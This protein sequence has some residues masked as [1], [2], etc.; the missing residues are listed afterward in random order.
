VKLTTYL[1]LVPRSRMMELYYA[2]R[3][4]SVMLNYAQGQLNRLFL[5]IYRLNTI[6]Q[7]YAH[8]TCISAY[9]FKLKVA[10][11][12]LQ[13]V[14]GLLDIRFIS[15]VSTKCVRTWADRM[16]ETQDS[17]S[18]VSALNR[19]LLPRLTVKKTRQYIFWCNTTER[20]AYI[21]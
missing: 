16:L 14:V 3:L 12:K 15:H 6:L 5:P 11:N 19:T 10:V 18:Q 13:E 7:T 20:Y 8:H 1:H 17:L 21:I 2:T 9:R 4:H